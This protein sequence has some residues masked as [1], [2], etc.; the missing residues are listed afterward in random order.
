MLERAPISLAGLSFSS[1]S[2]VVAAQ[3][4]L[5]E[6]GR[7]GGL[8]LLGLVLIHVR[9]LR[10]VI[11]V[12]AAIHKVDGLLGWEAAEEREASPP[13]VRVNVVMKEAQEIFPEAVY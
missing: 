7:G 6:V 11:A 10:P 9:V 5:V 3:V 4:E 1:K 2:F 8:D 12:P 13:V